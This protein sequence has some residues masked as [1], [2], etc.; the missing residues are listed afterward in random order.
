MTCASQSCKRTSLHSKTAYFKS[1]G[2][3]FLLLLKGGRFND[4]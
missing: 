4:L 1:F 3:S 2:N